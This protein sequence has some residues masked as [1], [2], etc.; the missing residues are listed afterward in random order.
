MESYGELLKK[1]RES[2]NI[3]IDTAEKETSIARRYI[4]ALE[5]ENSS[6]FPGEPYLFGFLH[7]YAEYLDLD[8]K[9]I[10]SLYK[11]KKLQESPIPEELYKKQKPRFLAP[12]IFCGCVVVIAV[13][14]VLAYIFLFPRFFPKIT[15]DDVA[16][17]KNNTQRQYM[18]TNEPLEQRVFKGDQIIV[19]TDSGNVIITVASTI[20]YLALEMPSGKM[21]VELSDE[22]QIDVDGDGESE[23]VAYVSDVSSSS[24]D[25]GAEVKIMLTKYV[26]IP[27]ANN[28]ETDD[29]AAS[30]ANGS[31]IF[32]DNRAY[33]FTVNIT[34]RSPCEFRWFVDRGKTTE[35]YYN[36]GDIVTMTPQNIVRLWM[37]NTNAV[38]IQ[39]IANGR[40]YNLEIGKAGQVTVEDIKWIKDSDGLYKVV[41]SPVD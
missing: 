18:L 14:V 21:I 23:I 15:E 2:K 39:V 32:A 1:A 8:S 40:T 41:V 36:E 10:I 19:P 37:A 20:S 13:A 11:N 7:N 5:S 29:G 33:P 9:T 35:N 4:E 17:Q 12:L 6:V 34:F 31:V 24:E 25:R 38:K 30:S 28:D 27:A 16:L 22:V 3:D 26:D